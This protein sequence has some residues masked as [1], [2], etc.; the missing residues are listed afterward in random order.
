MKKS[1]LKKLIREEIYS[2]R[3]IKNTK[4]PLKVGQ[5]YSVADP[6]TGDYSDWEYLGFDVSGNKYVFIIRGLYGEI[7]ILY[8]EKEFEDHIEY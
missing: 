5:N 6:R 3:E 7:E 1:Q 2:S 8:I 4:L